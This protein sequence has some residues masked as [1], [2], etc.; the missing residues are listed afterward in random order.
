M[1][2]K[3]Y[4]DKKNS[5]IGERRKSKQLKFR[6]SIFKNG[7]NSS[8][9]TGLMDSDNKKISIKSRRVSQF[10]PTNF[11]LKL[12]DPVVSTLESIEEIVIKQEADIK[13]RSR[14]IGS[15]QWLP[16]T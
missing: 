16:K 3:V 13:T 1:N 7:I 12:T 11:T 9:Q 5:I 8:N 10:I 4:N 6:G 14:Y 2:M 15:G